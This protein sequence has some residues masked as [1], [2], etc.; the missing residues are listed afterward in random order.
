MTKFTD[1]PQVPPVTAML[2]STLS[3][4]SSASSAGLVVT[5][6]ALIVN[7]AMR[8]ERRTVS[9]RRRPGSANMGA[10]PLG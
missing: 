10:S 4:R 3:V 2:R 8:F 5:R 9:S 6:D 7:R 1:A